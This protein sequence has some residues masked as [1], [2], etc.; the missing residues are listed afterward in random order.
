[1]HAVI[2]VLVLFLIMFAGYL[3]SKTKIAGQEAADAMSPIIMNVTLPCLLLNAFQRPFSAELLGEAGVSVAAALIMY[4]IALPLAIAYPHIIR[5]RG[6]ERGVH[7]Y[8]LLFS[9]CSFIGYPMVEAILGPQYLFH[10]CL[11]NIFYNLFAFTLG[12][13]V[14]AKEGDKKMKLSWQTFVNPC[15]M[16]TVAGFLLFIFSVSLPSPLLKGIKMTGDMTTPMSML[17]TGIVLARVK[18]R[19]VWGQWKIYVTVFIRLILLPVLVGLACVLF[20]IRRDLLVLAVIITAM[21]AATTT[22]IISALYRAAAGEGSAL[23]FMSTLLSMAT[24]PILVFVLQA[25]KLL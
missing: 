4:G 6:Q 23:V 3:C 8:A 5:T 20:G 19:L 10:A 15:V 14:I 16:A 21:P 2:Q 24:I 11:F 18:P 13:W 17:V 22:S 1:M 12:A 25:I 7:R 9:N